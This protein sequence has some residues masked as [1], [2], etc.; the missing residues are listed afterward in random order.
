MTRW[1]VTGLTALVLV[2]TTVASAEPPSI[3]PGPP[4]TPATSSPS[5]YDSLSPGKVLFTTL[6]FAALAQVGGVPPDL[7]HQA[8]EQGH[9]RVIVKVAR[10]D[11]ASET[12]E[13][14]QNAV[15]NELA[16]TSFKILHTYINSAFLALDVGPDALEALAYSPKVESIAA[17][18]DLQLMPGPRPP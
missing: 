6:C 9:V 16:G 1:I 4:A 12:I 18:F 2:G 17:D 5:A 14:A 11:S 15:L 8:R 13:A 7:L 3:P 10:D